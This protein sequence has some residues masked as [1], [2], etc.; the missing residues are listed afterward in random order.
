MR[1]L[2]DLPGQLVSLWLVVMSLMPPTL[3]ASGVVT[4][5]TEANLRAAVAGG[6][7]VRFACDGVI[8]VSNTV[9]LGGILPYVL[10]A[11]GRSVVISGNNTVNPFSMG[12][13]SRATISNLTIANTPGAGVSGMR[14]GLLAVNCTFTNC[15]G[16]GINFNAGKVTAIG[17]TFVNNGRGVYVIGRGGAATLMNCTFYGNGGTNGYTA[18][19]I[20]SDLPPPMQIVN[21]TVANNT[22][23][24][25]R[26]ISGGTV[27]TN[28]IVANNSGGD[29]SGVLDGGHNIVSDASPGITNVSSL[30]N[31]DPRLGPLA[32]NGGPSMTMALLAGSPALDAADDAAAPPV[33]Q[34]GVERLYGYG[35]DIGAFEAAK[36]PYT[37][38]GRIMG[39]GGS[40]GVTISAG[41][42]T[43]NVGVG[44]YYLRHVPEGTYPLAPRADAVFLPASRIITVGP[45]NVLD[46]DFMSYRINALTMASH[47][48]GSIQIVFAG[49]NGQSHAFQGARDPMG[50][51]EAFAT[52]VVGTNG[53]FFQSVTND[54]TDPIRYFRTQR[55]HAVEAR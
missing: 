46:A 12:L 22:G 23:I 36:A 7:L 38:G 31:T 2:A 43:S 1:V 39:Y 30:R 3:L 20:S 14:G 25:V 8:V 41:T 17:C 37:I 18:V 27:L 21:C 33:D 54:S 52:N 16:Y 35:S 6:G 28:S 9:S 42:I 26:G 48:N 15:A 45:S 11:S 24:G 51:W 47:S 29:C 40:N 44:R 4:N 10:D 32:N 55:A 5:C 49:S 50:A 13:D 34:R 53:V 19:Q